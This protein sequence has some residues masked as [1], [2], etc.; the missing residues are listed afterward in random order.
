M[1]NKFTHSDFIVPLPC[2]HAPS[3][4]RPEDP[5]LPLAHVGQLPPVAVRLAG[6][7]HRGLDRIPQPDQ[8]PYPLPGRVPW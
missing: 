1:L 6:L 3:L 5:H 7:H 4:L 2:L 8:R